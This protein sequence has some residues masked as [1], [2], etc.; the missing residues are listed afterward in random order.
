MSKQREVGLD[1]SSKSKGK[2]F[3]GSKLVDLCVNMRDLVQQVVSS[4]KA[5]FTATGLISE[6]FGAVISLE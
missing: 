3:G 5:S 2:K 1:W 4:I 6:S